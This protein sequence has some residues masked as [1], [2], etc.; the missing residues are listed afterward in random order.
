M[1]TLVLVCQ[2][3][4]IPKNA[5][6]QFTR[7]LL[8][9]IRKHKVILFRNW[10]TTWP[11]LLITLLNWLNFLYTRNRMIKYYKHKA[12]QLKNYWKFDSF[13]EEVRIWSGNQL[14]SN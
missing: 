6:Y 10:D 9:T 3:G 8:I 11:L 2:K 14:E 12:I 13:I 5:A 4:K 7:G 1:N